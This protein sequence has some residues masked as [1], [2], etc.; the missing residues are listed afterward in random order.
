MLKEKTIKNLKLQNANDEEKQIIIRNTFN[1][2][3]N[4]IK[5]WIDEK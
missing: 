4:K 5:D 3:N 1:F 2:I